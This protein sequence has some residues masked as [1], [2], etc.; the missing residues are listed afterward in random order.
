MKNEDDDDDDDDD[1]DH[2]DHHDFLKHEN[3]ILVIRIFSLI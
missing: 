3:K 2:D 1:Y